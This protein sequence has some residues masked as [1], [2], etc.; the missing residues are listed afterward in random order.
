MY[1]VQS[2]A[3]RVQKPF[4]GGDYDLYLQNASKNWVNV[5]AGL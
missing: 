1:Q 5:G 3:F 4:P 2:L